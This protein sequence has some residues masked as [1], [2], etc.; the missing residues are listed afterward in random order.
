MT[1]KMCPCVKDGERRKDPARVRRPKDL[2]GEFEAPLWAHGLMRKMG[3]NPFS[4]EDWAMFKEH[5]E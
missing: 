3:L 1:A 4:T 5:C 2:S